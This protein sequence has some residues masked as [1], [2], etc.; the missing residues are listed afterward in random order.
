LLHAPALENAAASRIIRPHVTLPW[1][2]HI[3]FFFR[4]FFQPHLWMAVGG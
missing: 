1:N 3:Y 2:G 4:I